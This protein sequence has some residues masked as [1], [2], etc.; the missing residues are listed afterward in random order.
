[1]SGVTETIA[2][3]VPSDTTSALS[4]PTREVPPIPIALNSLTFVTGNPKRRSPKTRDPAPV[5]ATWV[6]RSNGMPQVSINFP[7]APA[8]AATGSFASI[9]T[10][11]TEP[12]SN[13]RYQ[14]PQSLVPTPVRPVHLNL[15]S[16]LGFPP[17]AGGMPRH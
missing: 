12:L 2:V 7:S 3:P 17:L 9:V 11:C 13:H 16:P 1:L 5:A 15:P 6:S 14:F 4:L 10:T 8:A